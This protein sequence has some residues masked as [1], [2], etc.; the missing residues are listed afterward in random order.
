M[1]GQSRGSGQGEGGQPDQSHGD[2]LRSVA[3]GADRAGQFLDPSVAKRHAVPA[4]LP[5]H[6]QGEPQQQEQVQGAPER[7]GV[8]GRD[9]VHGWGL[10][11]CR[12]VLV[13]LRRP[14]VHRRFRRA[15][16]LPAVTGALQ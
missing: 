12:F 16:G 14:R 2:V 6:Q 5:D 8:T 10:H 9:R 4:S 3:E 11:S 15:N 13:A 7:Q 1:D